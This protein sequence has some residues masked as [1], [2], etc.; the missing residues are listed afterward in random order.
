MSEQ[1]NTSADKTSALRQP[2][3]LVAMAAIVLSI[4]GL[5][6]ALFEAS[7]AR[8][9]ER[10]SVWPHVEVATSVQGTEV[11]IFVR[12]SGVG[13]ARIRAAN[14]SYEGKV[15]DDWSQ[16]LAAAGIDAGSVFRSYSLIGGRVLGVDAE[17]EAIFTVDVK[18]DSA[19]P[20]A[21]LRLAT[22][23]FDGRADV[24]LCYCSVYDECWIARMQDIM[25]R[26]RV[27]QR[28]DDDAGDA[29]CATVP[30]SGI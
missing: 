9:A 30:Q 12:N 16:L 7:I 20:E 13:P 18:E 4:C 17:L 29:D 23:L 3:M 15:L 28:S 27:P 26:R 11:E 19:D 10:A 25:N 6:I 2:E 1:G 5:F 22:A 8:R 14:V 21:S 24:T